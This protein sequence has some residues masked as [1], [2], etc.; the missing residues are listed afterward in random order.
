MKPPPMPGQPHPVIVN[1]GDPEPDIATL[2]ANIKAISASMQRLLKSGLNRKAIEVLLN[3]DTKVGRHSIT[4][5]L[6]SLDDLAK[7]FTK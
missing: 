3:H 5:I 4:L 7:K 6:N 1:L 2:A